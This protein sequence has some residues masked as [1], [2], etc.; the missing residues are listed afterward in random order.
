[1]LQ[2]AKNNLEDLKSAWKL[3]NES[4]FVS[5]DD[6]MLLEVQSLAMTLKS[7]FVS[8]Y[9][10]FMGAAIFKDRL[11]SVM[12]EAENVPVTLQEQ[13]ARFRTENGAYYS[14]MLI[15]LCY[16]P[17]TAFLDVQSFQVYSI[18]FVIV[19]TFS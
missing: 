18:M 10:G 14:R 13:S 8:K 2:L 16:N 5:E 11:L 1:M 6:L 15:M 9:P 7:V 19:L 4:D 17:I 12:P 3:R